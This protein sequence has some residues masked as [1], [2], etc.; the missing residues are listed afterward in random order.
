[1]MFYLLNIL[2]G[3]LEVG[4]MAWAIREGYDFWVLLLFPFAYQIGNLF[5]KPFSVGKIPLNMLSA[6]SLVTSCAAL[7]IDPGKIGSVALFC[8][9][10]CAISIIIQSVRCGLKTDDNRM[11]KRITRVSGFIMAPVCAVSPFVCMLAFSMIA[12]VA[13]RGYQGKYA[14]VK[15]KNMKSFGAIMVFHQ[16]HYFF[17]VYPALAAVTLLFFNKEHSFSCL[18]IGFALFAVTWVTYLSTEYIL[19]GK[20]KSLPVFYTGHL[21]IVTLLL[22]M[23][24]MDVSNLW[25]LVLW[26]VMGFCGGTVYTIYIEAD[27]LNAR[28]ED[29]MT[30][31]ENIGHITGIIVALVL[32]FF[33]AGDALNITFRLSSAS[34]LTAITLM[35]LAVFGKKHK[36][37]EE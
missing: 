17:Y 36:N 37:K 15:M 27:K 6:L 24:F 2:S 29:S 7:F 10:I 9:N 19:K 35:T 23:S 13:L 12:F 32:S 30:V 28:D 25:F 31:C 5:P 16:L 1:M 33:Y 18:E 22:A 11:W 3:V 14:V 34:A 4:Y 20:T 8:F 21:G 26:I